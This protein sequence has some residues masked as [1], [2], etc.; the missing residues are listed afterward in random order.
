M[1][2]H[3]QQ[4]KIDAAQ[5]RA[6]YQKKKAKRSLKKIAKEREAQPTGRTTAPKMKF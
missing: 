2:K 6:A 3:K 1:K 4:R 5:K